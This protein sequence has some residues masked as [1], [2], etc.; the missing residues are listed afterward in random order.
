MNHCPIQPE[1]TRE[2]HNISELIFQSL[3]IPWWDDRTPEAIEAYSTLWSIISEIF[4]PDFFDDL[5]NTV[6]LKGI[7]ITE[8]HTVFAKKWLTHMMHF[9]VNE[10][11][12]WRIF[13][14]L[15]G[16]KLYPSDAE[17]IIIMGWQHACFL[18]WVFLSRAL[19]SKSNEAEMK[20]EID[21]TRRFAMVLARTHLYIETSIVR[22]L[23]QILS[24]WRI[25]TEQIYN[26]IHAATWFDLPALGCP[27]IFFGDKRVGK[28]LFDGMR[29][30][31]EQHYRPRTQ[32]IREP[33]CPIKRIRLLFSGI[34]GRL[35]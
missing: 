23:E 19:E 10:R 22:H 16:S 12:K 14:S 3:K 20:Q 28:S 15:K 11:K 33:A 35:K 18:I 29:W 6:D 4:T 30:K 2:L 21:E 5:S 8:A 24:E 17:T 31:M 27:A 13:P 7:D 32:I 34:L 9:F 25:N 26:G 1:L